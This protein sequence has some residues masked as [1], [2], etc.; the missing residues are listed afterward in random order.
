MSISADRFLAFVVHKDL[1][2]ISNLIRFD[3]LI[4]DVIPKARLFLSYE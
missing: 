2:G 3:S 1:F 4:T